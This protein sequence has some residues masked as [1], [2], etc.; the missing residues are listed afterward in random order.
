DDEKV[1]R[2]TE[3]VRQQA[4]GYGRYAPTHFTATSDTVAYTDNKPV[5]ISCVVTYVHDSAT[6]TLGDVLGVQ[7]TYTIA[8][9]CAVASVFDVTLS[10]CATSLADFR[11]TPG[12]MNIIPGVKDTV[13]I[14]DTYN[15]SPTAAERALSSLYEIETTGR[16]IAVL[17]DMLELGRYSVREHERVGE[18]VADGA[19]LLITVGI[20]SRGTAEG[21]LAFGMD[22]SAILQYDEAVRAGRELQNLLQ[23]GDVVLVKG[24][25]SMRMEVIVADIMANPLEAESKLVRQSTMWQAQ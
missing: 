1:R 10:Q 6:V 13:I 8:A 23:P 25:Q 21:A 7:H 24:S 18:Q 20:R 14:D 15:S 19:D 11:A 17:G 5:G 2:S 4:I 9:A 12:R 22:E 16:K 3:E